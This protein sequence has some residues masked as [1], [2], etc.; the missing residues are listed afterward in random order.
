MDE[1]WGHVKRS[2]GEVWLWATTE[3][4]TKIIPVLQVGERSQA[5]V[6]WLTGL[7]LAPGWLHY[8]VAGGGC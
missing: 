3:A 7:A 2:S 6:Y 4:K 8:L 1:L 5:L